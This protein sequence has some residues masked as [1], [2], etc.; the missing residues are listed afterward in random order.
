MTTAHAATLPDDFNLVRGGFSTHLA[1]RLGLAADTAARRSLK[2]ALL[3]LLTWAPLALLSLLSGHFG[4]S[5]VAISFLQDPE[6]HARFLVVLPLLELAEIMVSRS[7]TLQLRHLREMGLVPERERGRFDA[8]VTEALALRGAAWVEAVLLIASY[9]I[10]IVSR[11]VVGISEGASTW[12]RTDQGLTLAGWWLTLVGLPIL[13]FLVLRWF[14]VYLIWARLLYRISR[15]EL[16]LTPTHPD[17][18]GGLGFLGWGVAC[19]AA[20][21]VPISTV[22]SAGFAQLI[23]HYGESLN[24]MKYHI[25]AFI[26]TALAVIYA[27]LLVFSGRLARCRFQGLLELGALA[28][29]HDRMFDEKWLR[30]S[31]KSAQETIL[32]SSDVQ[33]MADIATCYGHVNEMRLIPFDM[34]AFAVLTLAA[35]LPMVPLVGTQI[36]LREIFMKLGELLI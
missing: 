6:V 16:E 17:R 8:A 14:W 3:V 33:S 35:L 7:L 24:S 2:V 30:N 11:L 25:A 20:V 5:H 23:L 36:P 34:R 31:P 28:W 10:V 27:P 4:F 18:A 1:R 32:G 22:L 21:L 9:S 29:L 19:F 13:Y 15:L 12:E 26:I